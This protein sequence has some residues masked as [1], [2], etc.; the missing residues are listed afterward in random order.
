MLDSYLFEIFSESFG[1]KSALCPLYFLSALCLMLLWLKAT[2]PDHFAATLSQTLHQA[3]LAKK[4]I[5][6]DAAY[7]LLYV[8]ALRVP[9]ALLHAASFQLVYQ[10]VLKSR[11]IISSL[12]VGVLAPLWVEGLLA[13][14]VSML[15]FD[16][17]AYL[18]HR[19]MHRFRW[20]WRIHATHH[21]TSFLTPLSNFRQHPLE[22]ILL[23][24]ARGLAAGAALGLFHLVFPRAT[25]VLLLGGLGLGFFLYMFTVHLH[26]APLPVRY[27]SWL[28][29]ILISPHQ[30]H[31]H[32]SADPRHYDKNFG[33]IFS[34][35]DRMAGTY[36]E[37]E[38]APNELT[39]GL[40]AYQDPPPPELCPS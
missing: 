18:T 11:D 17:A 35:W 34:I 31:I 20:L 5:C 6:V 27:P 16:G 13:T 26:H 10:Q 7:T 28:T 37:E 21:S 22:P 40:Q 36:W 24:L 19:A 4:A 39:F 15:A 2:L 23:A 25:P 3:T 1:L 8:I 30:H 32:H 12:G 38:L 14:L 33:V 9:T 29:I